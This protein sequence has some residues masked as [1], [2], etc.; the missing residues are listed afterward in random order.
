MSETDSFIEEVSEEVRR[1]RLYGVFKRY[2]WLILLVVLV[3]VGGATFNEWQKAQTRQ[4]SQSSGDAI[5]AALEQRDADARIDAL[6]QLEF[7]EAGKQALV[8]LQEAAMLVEDG[9]PDEAA[10]VLELVAGMANAGPVYQD[11]A[12]LK[13]AMLLPDGDLSGQALDTLATPGRPYRLLA[14]EQRALAAIRSNDSDAAL[15]DLLLVLQDP[16]T[17]PELRERAQQLTVVLGGELP[18][19]PSLLPVDGNG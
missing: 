2:G 3:I 18:Q 11:L 7:E 12:Q 4:A 17:T 13:L 15:A 10:A 9:R 16:Q 19:Q 1:D 5:L 14:I 6:S 8:K